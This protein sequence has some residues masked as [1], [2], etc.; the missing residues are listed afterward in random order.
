MCGA[1]SWSNKTTAGPVWNVVFTNV[2]S[3][4]STEVEW[5]EN[6]CVKNEGNLRSVEDSK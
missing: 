3:N 1:V 4:V 6:R 5:H 2:C